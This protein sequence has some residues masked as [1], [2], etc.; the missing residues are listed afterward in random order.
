MNTFPDF[1]TQPD[2]TIQI[3][4]KNHDTCLL[5]QCIPRPTC[6]NIKLK[7]KL[8]LTRFVRSMYCYLKLQVNIIC[9]VT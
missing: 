4:S 6:Y 2:T 7:S 8:M 3:L 1:Y 5:I 9:I